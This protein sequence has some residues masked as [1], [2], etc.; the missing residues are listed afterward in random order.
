[1][2]EGS[3]NAARLTL[4]ANYRIH[5]VFH[6]SLLKPYHADSF[7]KPLPPEPEVEE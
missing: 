1:M 2:T 4:P 7:S 3:N 6:V 5:P